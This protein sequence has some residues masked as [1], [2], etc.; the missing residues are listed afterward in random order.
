MMKTTGLAFVLILALMMSGFVN[1]VPDNE[2]DSI[3]A[4][5]KAGNAK[6]LAKYFSANIELTLL[7]KEDVYSKAQAEI[8][9]KDFFSKNVPSNYVKLHEGGKEGAK[10]VIGNLTTSG[11]TFRVYFLLKTENSKPCIQQLRIETDNG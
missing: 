1:S 10:F 6:E 5:L 8:I 4:A 11:G 7:D 2:T 3:I 9:I